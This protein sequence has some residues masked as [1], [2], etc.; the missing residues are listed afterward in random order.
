[1]KPKQV[2]F[3]KRQQGSLDPNS[4]WAIAREKGFKQILLCQCELSSEDEIFNADRDKDGNLPEQ[5]EDFF[6]ARGSLRRGAFLEINTVGLM[7]IS[8]INYSIN[9]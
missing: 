4:G 9:N 7:Q 8:T 1:M 5:S 2:T 3:K 6:Q